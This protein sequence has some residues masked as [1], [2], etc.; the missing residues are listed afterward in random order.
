VAELVTKHRLLHPEL[1]QGLAV[2]PDGFSAA[3]TVDRILQ[4][5]D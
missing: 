2:A 4:H 1:S 5:L 3:Q